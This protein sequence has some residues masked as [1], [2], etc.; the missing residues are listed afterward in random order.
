MEKKTPMPI[1]SKSYDLLVWLLKVTRHFPCQNR[2]NF[3]KRL[4]DSAFDFREH[5]EAANLR[6]I[7]ERFQVLS[8]ADEALAKLQ[9]YIKLATKMLWLSKGQYAHAANRMP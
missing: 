2:H 6:R 5:L 1:F 7:T 8:L 4:L 9:L 3:T